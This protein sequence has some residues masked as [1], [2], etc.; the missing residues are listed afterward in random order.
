MFDYY[1]SIDY[2]Q[3]KSNYF[4]FENVFK[5]FMNI[6]KYYYFFKAVE[7][8]YSGRKMN[9]NEALKIGFVNEIVDSGESGRHRLIK[10]IKTEIATYKMV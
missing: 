6:I 5:L 3:N 7:F 2:G 9:V 1:I 10:K 8:L 4:I